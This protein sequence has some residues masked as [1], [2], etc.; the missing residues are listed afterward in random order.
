L[1]VDAVIV[2]LPND[3]ITLLSSKGLLL[4]VVQR[5]YGIGDRI[6]IANPEVPGDTSGSQGWIVED[7]TLFTTTVCL[8]ATSE[9]ATIANGML[10]KSRIINGAR[11][12]NAIVYVVMR[13]GIET[14][15][16]KVSG[17]ATG[18]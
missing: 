10:A 5:P 16:G 8:A 15:Y 13:F 12:P 3:T 17:I 7:V 18:T 14:S 2:I 6:N 9:R 11:S 4:I 1:F